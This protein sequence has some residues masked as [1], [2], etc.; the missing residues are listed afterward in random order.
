MGRGVGLRP[1]DAALDDALELAERHGVILAT[2]GD[3][4]RVPGAGGAQC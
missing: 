1:A 4:M 2:Y 3:M